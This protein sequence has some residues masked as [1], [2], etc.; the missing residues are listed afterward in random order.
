MLG[1]ADSKAHFAPTPKPYSNKKDRPDPVTEVDGVT[2]V[3]S[4]WAP[5]ATFAALHEP[6]ENEPRVGRFEEIGRTDD[7][8]AARVV[9]RPGTGIDDR[10]MV[11]TGPKATEPVTL[12]GGGE[13]FTFAGHAF[14]RAGAEAIVVRG[15]LRAMTLRLGA[16]ATK[17]TLVVNGREVAARAT[18]DGRLEWSP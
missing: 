18:A 12:E 4:R 5:S 1:E 7:A 17:R 9:G 6:Y 11:R 14:V 13:R 8:V 2:I 15:D 3:A 10:L 16:G